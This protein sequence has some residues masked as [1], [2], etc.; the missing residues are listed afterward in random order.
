MKKIILVSI[1]L[2]ISFLLSAQD[3][4]IS[5]L[6]KHVIESN[7]MIYRFKVLLDDSNIK[8]DNTTYYYWFKDGKIHKNQGGYSGSLLSGRYSISSKQ[9]ALLEE[10]NYEIGRKEGKW[11]KWNTSGKLIELSNWKHGKLHGVLYQYTDDEVIKK[12][13]KHG[14]FKK[15]ISP[16]L[17]K[18]KANEKA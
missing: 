5:N 9:G 18:K 11:K 6:K 2:I 10:G 4:V 17:E 8:L 13:Y 1:F 3:F 15:Q 7:E 16:K 12:R 14:L